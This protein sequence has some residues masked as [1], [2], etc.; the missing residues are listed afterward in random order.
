[1][2][3]RRTDLSQHFLN[4]RKIAERIVACARLKGNRV[5]EI[6]P[7]KGI[8]T[9]AIAHYTAEVHAI[10]LDPVMVD[11][12]TREQY[13][14]VRVVHD[15][16]LQHDIRQYGQVV[17][18]GNIPYRVSSAIIEKLVHDHQA[19]ISATLTVQREFAQR[20]LA[21]PGQRSYGFLTLFV[22]CFFTVS[23]QFNIAP[24]FF[25]PS[26]AVSSTVVRLDRVST[27]FTE[28]DTLDFFD[29]VRAVFRYPRKSVKNALALVLA[30][31]PA[32]ISDSLL[33]KRPGALNVEDIHTLYRAVNE[34]E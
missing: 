22:R 10:E 20:L 19:I 24:R 8:L 12:L 13:Q 7:G 28:S 33:Q 17:V 23:R 3:R 14:G 11:T 18:V 2:K 32:G 6:G 5:V 27:P 1:M 21:K 26:P 4:S 15:D 29:C 31:V 25:T 16:F 30:E 34:A 9:R